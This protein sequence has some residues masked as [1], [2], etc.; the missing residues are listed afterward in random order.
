MSQAR[1]AARPGPAYRLRAAIRLQLLDDEA[2][3]LDD[4]ESF[5]EWSDGDEM[6]NLQRDLRF[7]KLRGDPRFQSIVTRY[8]E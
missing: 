7:K 1:F 6:V 2:G 4:L 3:A 8:A 5:A